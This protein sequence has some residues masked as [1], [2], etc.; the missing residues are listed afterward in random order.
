MKSDVER[1]IRRTKE[2]LGSNAGSEG[3]GAG[4]GETPGDL[5]SHLERLVLAHGKV[6]RRIAKLGGADSQVGVL[7]LWLQT[8]A[9]K[10]DLR[11]TRD[12]S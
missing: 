11:L 2:A 6:E 4:K 12:L 8:P 9:P 10:T 3:G 5:R 7:S 1:E